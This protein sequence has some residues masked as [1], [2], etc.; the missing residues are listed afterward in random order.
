MNINEFEK[1]EDYTI[2]V[3]E[4][5]MKMK[6]QKKHKY[7]FKATEL[8]RLKFFIRVEKSTCNFL[9]LML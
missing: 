9:P 5:K 1:F 7:F 8:C 2:D 3:Y 4:E 6:A